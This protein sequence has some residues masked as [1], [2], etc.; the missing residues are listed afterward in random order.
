[1]KKH[2]AKDHDV[3]AENPPDVKCDHL[4]YKV[5]TNQAS[6]DLLK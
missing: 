4:K 5:E 6:S 1:V 2:H 3:L